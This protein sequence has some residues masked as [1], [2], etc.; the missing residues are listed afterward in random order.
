MQNEDDWLIDDSEEPQDETAAAPWPVLI[1]DDE[2]DI[3]QVTRLALN[4]IRFLGRPLELISCHSGSEAL[5]L[6][7]RRDDVALM[8][9]DV[10]MESEDA[11]LK[12]ARAV[13]EELGNHRVRI[14]LRTGQPGAAPE[15]D[16][17]ESYDINDYK[18]KTELTRDKLYTAVLG[19]LRSYRDI[20]LIEQQRRMLDANRRGLHKVI[21]ASSSIFQ[22][23][24]IRQF[25]Q[26]VLEQL[27]AL[28]FFE[29]EALYVVV[30]GGIATL[31]Q[32]DEPILVLYA[33]GK[34]AALRDQ[35][36]PQ[37]ELE[38]FRPAI[39]TAMQQGGSVFGADHFVGFFRA[40][41]GAANLLIIDGPV[42]LSHA[43][44]DLVELFCRNATIAFENLMLHAEIEDGQRELI[45]RLSDMMEDRSPSAGQH[46]RRVAEYA[47][48]IALALG[49]SEDDAERL[50]MVTPL[51]DLGKMA[52]PDAVLDK[53]TVLDDQERTLMMRHPQQGF[54]LLDHARSRL[55]QLAALIARQHHERWDGSGYPQGLA[56]EAI[57][58]AA[59]IV[60]LADVYDALL[61]ARTYKPA[62]TRDDTLATIRTGRGTQFDPAVVDA[63]FHVL[64]QLEAVT[65]D[66]HDRGGH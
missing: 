41:Q 9:L 25:A 37:Q 2:P 45:Y 49:W 50:R 18:A 62:W 24:S 28:L 60:A 11:G 8:L 61:N 59:R 66:G 46:V 65:A 20:M 12:V 13:R 16:V 10:V 31:A 52:L 48:L 35:P 29:Q 40:R 55:L 26:G 58:P 22:L 19:T 15:R 34:Y 63:F 14:I 27:Q 64:P 21:D 51:H 32:D 42:A 17:I 5:A 47:Y 36:L 30:E 4:G 7:A 6:L 39:D 23:Q 1:V 56:G 57:H 33:T 53:P 38:R 43:D 44:R 54:E 3:H